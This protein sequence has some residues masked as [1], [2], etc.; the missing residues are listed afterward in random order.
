MQARPATSSGV[1]TSSTVV[2]DAPGVLRGANLFGDGTNSC[3]LTI[4]DNNAAS[5][6]GLI[7]GYL[8][9]QASGNVDELDGSYAIVCN[10][11]A[12]AVLTGS[13]SPSFV[14]YYDKG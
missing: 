13:G 6:T 4:Y 7:V 8:Q 2:L 12:Y 1:K 3:T 14:V 9:L 10:K 5:A 11:G